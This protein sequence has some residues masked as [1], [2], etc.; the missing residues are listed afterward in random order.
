MSAQDRALTRRHLLPA[1]AAL[2]DLFLRL[3]ADTDRAIGPTT[4]TYAGKPYPYGCCL[5]ITNDVLER[6]KARIARPDHEGVRAVRAFLTAGGRGQRVWGVLRGRYFQN[7]L[8][9][10]GLYVDVA[11]DT[12]D[13]A[14]PKVEILPM[15]EAGLEAVR[16]AWHF[17][18]VA[19]A[20]WGLRI[21]AN[22]A[23]PSLAPLLP[24]IGLRPDGRLRLRGT[25]G[26]MLDLFQS[27]GF[28]RAED[29]LGRGPV[30]PRPV[31]E[32]LR[33]ACS[34]ELL[35]A[36]PSAG[37][38]AAVLACRAARASGRAASREWRA[39]RLA[40]FQQIGGAR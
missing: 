33:A 30:P 5:E 3:R 18:A 22:H 37:A 29:W 31:V 24:M 26:Y 8:Q 23:L 19:E 28:V 10:G 40:E 38:E 25:S 34:E 17:A 16:D 32:A 6:L 15:A 35:A 11:N 20:Y 1:Q 21:F 7:A 4:R 39:A 14:K 2:E 13:G 9:F 36:N 12:V 27:D